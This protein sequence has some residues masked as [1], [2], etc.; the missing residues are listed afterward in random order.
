VQLRELERELEAN[1]A[2]YQSYLQRAR[3]TAEQEGVD[4]TNARVITNA[5]PPID[6]SGPPRRLIVTGAAAGGFA[7][8]LLLALLAEFAGYVRHRREALVAAEEEAALR[9]S[10]EPPPLTPAQD[11]QTWSTQPQQPS[12]SNDLMRLL[13]VMSQLEKALQTQ[14][15]K[16]R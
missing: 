4:T 5:V 7:L 10:Q 6:R 1:R 8:G 12:S 2:V 11:Y 16:P 14:Q 9:A 15:G 3:E 13:A